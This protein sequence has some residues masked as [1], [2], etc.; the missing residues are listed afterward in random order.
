MPASTR[1]ALLECSDLPLFRGSRWYLAGGTALA[2]QVGH[3]QSVDLDFFTPLARYGEMALERR[4]LETG[5]WTTDLREEGTLYGRLGGAKISFIAYPFFA[6]S[7]RMAA[8]G[9]LRILLPEDIAVMKVIA[10]S[11]RGRKRDF[12]DLYWYCR[13]R[14]P[15]LEVIG[16]VPARYPGRKHSMV[17]FLKSLTYF[18][19]AEG[20]PMPRLFFRATWKDVREF[21]RR[22]VPSITRAVLDL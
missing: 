14:E 8:F 7:G 21:F 16:R 20:D 13:N 9:N 12:I 10:I 6:P 3:R 15:L 1:R 5:R 11:Q 18:A 4:L 2:L 17:H 19:D 22:E